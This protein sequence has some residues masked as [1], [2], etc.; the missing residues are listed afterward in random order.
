MEIDDRVRREQRSY[1]SGSVFEKSATM[2]VRF[3]HVFAS[4]NTRYGHE[5]FDENVRSLCRDAVVLD[6]GCLNGDAV[7]RY[8]QHGARRIIGIDISEKGIAEA[9]RNYGNR[10]ILCLRRA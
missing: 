6:Y 7:P 3:K 5:Y 10:G 9:A 8:R 1:D 2:Q 4:K